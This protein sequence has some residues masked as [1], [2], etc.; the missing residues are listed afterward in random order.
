MST[1]EPRIAKYGMPASESHRVPE[2]HFVVMQERKLFR[3]LHLAHALRAGPGLRAALDGL[4]GPADTATAP[5]QVPQV[6][7]VE[8]APNEPEDL[9]ALLGLK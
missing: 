6:V 8:A 3:D 1:D 9:R 7:A 2:N 4:A 5:Q